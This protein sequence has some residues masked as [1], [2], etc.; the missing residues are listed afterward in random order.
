MSRPDNG[1]SETMTRG[2][3]DGVAPVAQ[4]NRWLMLC[5]TALH[6]LLPGDGYWLLLS[7]SPIIRVTTVAST[8][9]YTTLCTQMRA[10]ITEH[11]WPVYLPSQLKYKH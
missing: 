8:R 3:G 4:L 1:A 2:G 5:I 11:P 6:W 7:L 10:L 9:E